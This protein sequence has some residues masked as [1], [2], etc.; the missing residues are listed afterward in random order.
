[1]GRFKQLISELRQEHISDWWFES[2][3]LMLNE[4]NPEVFQ[5]Q[6][7]AYERAFELI[8]LIDWEC[9]KNKVVPIFKQNTQDR[10]KQQFFAQLNEAFAYEYL[11]SCGYNEIKF[12]S[13]NKKRKVADLSF[14]SSQ[15]LGECEVKSI[16]RS[17][18]ELDRA[19]GGVFSSAVYA[20]LSD[21]FFNKLKYDADNALSKM[22]SS[23]IRI[24]Y[25]IIAFDD[26]MLLFL[27]DYR[28]QIY[29]FFENLYPSTIF[30]FQVGLSRNHGFSFGKCA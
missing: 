4:Q 3:E 26:P 22:S 11:Y 20:E 24:V 29:E 15:M 13:E 5:P 6:F 21:G 25:F 1:M 28:R 12:Q 16:F 17:Q 14:M 18:D 27:K 8:P 9:F 19:N 23:Q 7:D 30:Y 10:G 2:Y